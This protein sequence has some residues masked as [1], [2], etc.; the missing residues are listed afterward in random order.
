MLD[1]E[2]LFRQLKLRICASVSPHVVQLQSATCNAGIYHSYESV[3][4][5]IATDD[6]LHSL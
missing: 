3:C 1:H 4:M 5:N 6:R 2:C